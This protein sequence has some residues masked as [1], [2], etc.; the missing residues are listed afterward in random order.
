MIINYSIVTPVYNRASVVIYSILSSL[1][2]IE[3]S[4][5]NGE[6]IVVDDASSD[7]TYNLISSQF[8][9]EILNSSIRVIRLLK[10]IGP[11]GAKQIGA[12]NSRGEWIFFM[13]SDDTFN[14][15]FAKTAC[16]ALESGCEKYS[17]FFFR[18]INSI[19]GNIIG[20]PMESELTLSLNIFLREGTPG[21]CLPVVRRKYL[22]AVPFYA[23]LRGF[24][25]L[26]YAQIISR[27]GPAVILPI[28]LRNYCTDDS[29]DRVSTS[30]AIK[31]RGCLLSKGYLIMVMT[32]GF[33][34]EF[35]L[36]PT[37][38]RIIYHALNCLIYN[39]LKT[40]GIKL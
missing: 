12:E 11:S 29:G 22:L 19:D 33:K 23:G 35:K 31:L 4:G 32:F 1:R 34:L 2:F 13:D 25:S 9:N 16:L 24:E 17:I 3:E 18:C 40:I 5:L 20:R 14:S 30:R 26:T 27:Y 6:V 36:I 8:K 21:E 15:G 10:N 38:F 39:K 37:I 7:D 28:V